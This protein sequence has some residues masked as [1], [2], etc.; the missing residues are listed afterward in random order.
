MMISPNVKFVCYSAP[1]KT[2]GG[3]EKSATRRKQF[4]SSLPE[5]APLKHQSLKP[6]TLISQ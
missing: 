3:K 1:G 4:H 6:S 2:K 5:G